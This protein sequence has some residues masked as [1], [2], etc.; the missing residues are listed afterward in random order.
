MKF[1][2]FSISALSLFTASLSAQVMPGDIA[3]PLYDARG[4]GTEGELGF[5]GDDQF[6][7][8]ALNT[9]AQGETITLRHCTRFC[10]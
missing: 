10:Y 6:A 5:E 7:F 1:T 4:G 9:I 8:V 3:F 2:I